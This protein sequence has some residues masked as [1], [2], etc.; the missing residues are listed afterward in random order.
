MGFNFLCCVRH[1]YK[2]HGYVAKTSSLYSL[3]SIFS[4]IILLLCPF[5]SCNVAIT[6]YCRLATLHTIVA[7]HVGLS[8]PSSMIGDPRWAWAML[9]SSYR[10]HSL[11]LPARP[12]AALVGT[13]HHRDLH[14]H[15]HHFCSCDTKILA[16]LSVAFVCP[17]LTQHVVAP[18]YDIE[19]VISAIK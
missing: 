5:P 13:Y 19:G 7:V 9:D 3:K 12:A 8:A 1:Y 15:V 10:F 16:A 18:P 2:V 14:A 4:R 6:R 17:W 11:A